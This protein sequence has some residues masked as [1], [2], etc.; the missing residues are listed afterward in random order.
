[1]SRDFDTQG[2]GAYN[3]NHNALKSK[4]PCMSFSSSKRKSVFDTI[5]G[6]KMLGPGAYEEQK[7]KAGPSF[8][9]RGRSNLKAKDNNPGPGMYNPD[10]NIIKDKI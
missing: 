1:M 2:P 5:T 6:D 7:K 10:P 8:T 4:N 9:M 3:P